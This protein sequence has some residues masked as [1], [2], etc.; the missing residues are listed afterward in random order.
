VTPPPPRS[1]SE[2]ASA[3]DVVEF[4]EI[5][6][7]EFEPGTTPVAEPSP[8]AEFAPQADLVEWTPDRAAALVRGFGYTLHTVDPAAHLPGGD[9]LWRATEAEAREIGAP[10]SRIL[11]RYEPARRLAGV[12]DEAELGAAFVSYAKRNMRDRG[13]VVLAARDDEGP[14][15][16]GAG[17][18]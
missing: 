16:Y 10:L 13:R 8:T 3:G 17:E 2:A 9:E 11:A 4:P 15:V 18:D 5:R 1:P 6:A 7:S 12:V 14:Q